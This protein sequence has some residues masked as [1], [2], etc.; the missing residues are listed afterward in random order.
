MLHVE[1]RVTVR[2]N[3]KNR[4]SVV[5]EGAEYFFGSELAEDLSVSRQ[6]FWRWRTE[7]KIPNGRRFRGSRVVFN[8][9]EVEAIRA[10]ANLLEPIKAASKDQLRLFNGGKKE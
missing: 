9:D 6:T 2:D 8:K 4:G 3:A 1:T 10:Y 5:I 7:G